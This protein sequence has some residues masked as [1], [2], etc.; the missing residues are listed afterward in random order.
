MKA[1]LL[2]YSLLFLSTGL[3]AQ[4]STSFT[5]QVSNNK[6]SF[7]ASLPQLT[8]IPGAPAPFYTYLWDFGDGHYSTEANPEHV[9]STTGNYVA[10]LYAVNNYD[11]GKKPGTKKGKVPVTSINKSF[12]VATS[13]AEAN[14]F[15]A[16]GVFET[17]YNCMA[18]PGD[19]MVLITGWKTMASAGKLFLFINEES[20]GDKCFDTSTLDLY[21]NAALLTDKNVFASI[22]P[23]QDLK[24]SSSGS[25]A[26]KIIINETFDPAQS[27]AFLKSLQSGYKDVLSFEVAASPEKESFIFLKL[28]VTPDMLKDTSATI[29]ISGLFVPEEG[30]AFLHELNIPIVTSHDPNKMSLQQGPLSYR[31]LSKK[32]ELPYKIR[33]QNNGE[34][35]ARMIALHVTLPAA[36]DPTSVIVKEV[37]PNCL[38]C[39]SLLTTG[40]YEILQSPGTDSLT[41]RFNGIYLPGSQQQGITDY[42]STQGFVS[43]S[44]KAKK[45]LDNKPFKGKTAIVFDK[46]PPVITNFATGRFRKSLSPII[47][48]G[49]EGVVN[50]FTK[51]SGLLLGIGLSPLASRKIYWQVELLATS[52]YAFNREYTS[53]EDGFVTIDAVSFNYRS[54]TGVKYYTGEKIAIPIQARYNA[55]RSFG[56]GAGLQTETNLGGKRRE[57]NNYI[58]SNN[59]PY[60]ESISEKQKAFTQFSFTPFIDAQVGKVKYGPQLGTRFY[61]RDKNQSSLFVYASWRL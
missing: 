45:K 2:F 47:M 52:G 5:T 21:K 46:N 34:G 40:C 7:A 56:V 48:A 25:P 22:G 23:L 43:F 51:T 9:Y 6:V 31:A 13:N 12:A 41:F 4:D 1:T 8:Q 30:T 37:S 16:N 19:S 20:F 39:D 53:G 11:D 18:K 38:P 54:Y 55:G 29:V 59:P 60:K 27:Q 36:L 14:F 26:S 28:L 24:M 50:K 10:K 44:V 61:I 32:K 42:D 3:L 58:L 33:F 17:K 15:K 57:E 49:Y 35:P